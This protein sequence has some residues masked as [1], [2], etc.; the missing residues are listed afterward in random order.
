MG[1]RKIERDDIALRIYVALLANA[2]VT[3]RVDNIKPKTYDWI[4]AALDG[5]YKAADAF[6]A[7]RAKENP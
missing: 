4:G 3:V 2:S 1:E 7:R 6:L 5:A